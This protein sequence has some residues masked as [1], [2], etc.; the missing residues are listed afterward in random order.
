[1]AV[2]VNNHFGVLTRVTGLFSRRGYN[3]VS[4]SVGETHQPEISRITIQTRA[5]GAGVHQIARQLEK[6][7]DIHAVEILPGAEIIARELILAKLEAPPAQHGALLEALSGLPCRRPY[8][9]ET[10]IVLE[11][12]GCPEECR[13]FLEIVARYTIRELC[14]TGV[15]A[16][17]ATRHVEMPAL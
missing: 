6:L 2:L 16:M 7:E 12:T 15:T 8:H 5:D 11:L 4:L 14:R 17:A 9:D 10:V 1:L 3:I 13:L